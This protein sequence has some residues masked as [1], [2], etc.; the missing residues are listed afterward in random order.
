MVRI[1]LIEIASFLVPF[2]LFFVWRWQTRADVKLTAT[3]ALKLG[4]AG[5]L[6]AILVLIIMVVLESVRGGHAGD[7]YVPPRLENGR[8]VPGHFVPEDEPDDDDS[9]V[10]DEP[11]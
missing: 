5:A 10:D 9:P 1:T 4:L 2:L 8:V 6:L 11:Q 7:Q 3:P